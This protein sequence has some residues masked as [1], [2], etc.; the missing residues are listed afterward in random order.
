MW[1][2]VPFLW[3]SLLWS[4]RIQADMEGRQSK[5]MFILTT[6]PNYTHTQREAQQPRTHKHFPYYMDIFGKNILKSKSRE[7]LEEH[8][9]MKSL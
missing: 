5:K 9:Q 3:R 2:R 4:W 6:S 8:F 7:E 1:K